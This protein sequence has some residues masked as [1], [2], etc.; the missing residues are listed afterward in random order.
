[1]APLGGGSESSASEPAGEGE[2]VAPIAEGTLAAAMASAAS[3]G[4]APPPRVQDP[5]RT[6]FVGGLP[7]E[8]TEPVLRVFFAPFGTLT[9][10]RVRTARVG[11]LLRPAAGPHAARAAGI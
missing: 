8:A 9:S 3:F 6:V 1:M 4:G 11:A 7:P 5:S 10:V 2:A